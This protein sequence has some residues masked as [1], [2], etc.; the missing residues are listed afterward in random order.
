MAKDEILIKI[1]TDVKDA[2]KGTKELA[3]NTAEAKTE[4]GLLSMAMGKFKMAMAAAGKTA[5]LLF[6]SIK[7]GIMSTGI[8]ALVLA[9]VSLLSYFKKTQR[10]AE[11]LERAMAGF[12]AVV[13]VITDLFSKAGEMMVGAFKNPKQAIADLWAAIKKNLVNRVEGLIDSF[14]ALGKVIKGVFSLDWDEVTEGAKEYGTALIQVGTGMDVEQQKNFAKGIREV[15]KEMNNEADAAMRL[16]GILQKIRREEMEFT[17]VQAKTRQDVAKARLLAM[18]ETKS[19]EERLKAINQVMKKEMQMTAGLISLQKKKVAAKAAE[20]ALGESM[21]EDE[22][23]LAGLEVELIN[24]QTQSFTTQKRLMT[25]V[26]A[27]T[28]QMAAKKKA[29]ADAIAAIEKEKQQKI[30]EE[31]KK[32]EEIADKLRKKELAKSKKAAA[33]KVALEKLVEQEKQNAIGMGFEAAAAL[34]GEHE[35][36]SKGIAVAK[37]VYN[38][39]QA[40]M[41]AMATVPY[42]WN[43]V[44]AVATGVMGAVAVKKILSTSS[45][46]GGGGGGGG[47]ISAPSGTPSTT[48]ASGAFTLGEGITPEPARAYVVSD[49][50]TASQDKLANIRRRATI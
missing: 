3:S 22:E 39:Q 46:S 10:G 31:L 48:V 35:E 21:I 32:T 19:E 1:K 42:P 14:K 15:A 45:G 43:I 8:G 11:M 17:K 28:L 2:S 26:E 13:D 36:A 41:N 25:E 18:D 47:S 50:I 24:L 4:T 34:A 12:G 9:V 29:E 37:T 44:Q 27:L 23:E 40:I 33:D 38:T 5:K 7:A 20:L 30:E 16:K 6:G 49:D